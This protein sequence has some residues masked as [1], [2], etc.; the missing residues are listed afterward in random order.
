[1]SASCLFCKIVAGEIPTTKV[2]ESPNCLAFRDI[3][4][5]APTHVLVIPKKHYT[6]L[7]DLDDPAL[8]G[9]LLTMARDIAK[10]EGRA[11][12][13]YRIVVNTNADGGQTVFHLHVHVLGGR[14]MKW[15]PG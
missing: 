4:P 1:M 3:G 12:A 10:S 5:K 11:D 9:E 6:S 2:L 7:N 14:A 13:G 15:P 8:A